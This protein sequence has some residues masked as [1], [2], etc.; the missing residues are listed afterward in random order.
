MAR[1]LHN[2]EADLTRFRLR[3]LVLAL[4]VLL[5]FGLVAARVYVLQVVRY[6]DLA[7]QA[8]SNRTAVVPIVPNRG[9]IL[10]RSGLVMAANYSAYA[11]EIT[12]SK[13]DDVEATIDQL[14]R[15]VEITPLDRRRFKRLR[16]ESRS[17]DS[18]PLRTGLTDAEVARFTAQRY[19]FPGVEV[20]ARLFRTYPFGESAAHVLGYVGRINATE[21]ESIEESED[22]ANY[23]GTDVIGKLGVEQ[24]HE[25]ELHGTTGVEQM[26]TSAGGH[27]VRQLDRRPAVDGDSLMLTLDLGLQQMVETLYGNRRGA[28]VAIDPRNGEVLAFVSKPTYDPN[29]F[30]GGIDTESWQA[31]NES[32]NKPMLNRALRG[33]YPPGSTY[34]PFMALAALETGKRTPG[35]V[36][37]DRGSWTF[38]GHTFRSGHALGAVDLHRS[39]VMSSNVYYYM[40]A[41]D[42]GVDLIHDFMSP[43]GFGRPTG[44]DLV[45][46]AS[47]ILP[48][49]DWKRRTYK[50]PAQQKWMAGETISLGIGQ[51]YNNFTMIQL[52]HALG[53]IA[54]G[55]T[56]FTPHLVKA[57]RS[58]GNTEFVP[59]ET[60]APQAMGYK[61]DNMGRVRQGMIGVTQQGTA[62]RVFAGAPYLSGG[63]TGT[64]QAVTIGQRARYDARRLSE[65]QRDHSLYIAFAPAEEPR[66]VVAAIVENAGFGAAHAA[67]LAR[68][69]FDYWLLG[70]YPSAADVAAVQRGQAGAP[71]GAPRSAEEMRPQPAAGPVGAGASAPASAAA[72]AS[73]PASGVAS[74]AAAPGAVV[75]APTPST[76]RP[77]GA[78]EAPAAPSVR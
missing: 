50:R 9:E 24:S 67:P 47:G 26:E 28:L 17:F 39:I 77:A 45:G 13:V 15:L 48:S 16:E 51:G 20:R 56:G 25:R 42:M 54:N 68:R 55:G 3:A 34:K 62:R 40:L 53:I 32:I 74:A 75:T 65:Y 78:G 4:V 11:L 5:A 27:P 43:L 29:L 76:P 37:M 46:E 71:I 63:K 38:G 22:A 61:P 49:T 12:P 31:L 70:R 21:K 7:A 72:S 2:P 58:A 73:A 36:I 35:T 6:D 30:I 69:V 52:A 64:A 19:R 44:I 10:D 1:E 14:A 8:E 66:I 41:N 60:P 33:T 57:K 18:L 23:R 59:I